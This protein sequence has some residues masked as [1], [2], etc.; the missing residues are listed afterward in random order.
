MICYSVVMPSGQTQRLPMLRMKQWW[1]GHKA[2]GPVQF[3][4]TLIRSPLILSDWKLGF[5]LLNQGPLKCCLCSI[6]AVPIF[7]PVRIL[8]ISSIFSSGMGT[9]MGLLYSTMTL[10]LTNVTIMSICLYKCVII[11]LMSPTFMQVLFIMSG[12]WCKY[13]QGL[14]TPTASQH[15]ILTWQNPVFLVDLILV[16]G[17]KPW[18]L[19]AAIQHSITELHV[20][21]IYIMRL[22]NV[23]CE[24]LTHTLLVTHKH[25]H[26]RTSR[27]A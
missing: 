12:I 26:T 16:T 18:T 11:F 8:L 25:T 27:H 17:L 21:K 3:N 23:S 19:A 10:S 20:K 14:G 9:S 1:Q 2:K 15:N 6:F 22:T 4:Y 5:K 24:Q 7:F 13:I